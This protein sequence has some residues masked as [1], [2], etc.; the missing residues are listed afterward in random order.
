M[1]TGMRPT[2]LRPKLRWMP[3][4]QMQF[5]AREVLQKIFFGSHQFLFAKNSATKK[6]IRLQRRISER[7]QSFGFWFLMPFQ[8]GILR[9]Q[10]NFPKFRHFRCIWQLLSASFETFYP[11]DTLNYHSSASSWNVLSEPI[12]S[13]SEWVEEMWLWIHLFSY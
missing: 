2:S 5:L 13:R 7:Q 9:H 3:R 12:S 4:K 6:L 10:I 11:C 1:I 8:N